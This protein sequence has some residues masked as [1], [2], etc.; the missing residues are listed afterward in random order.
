MTIRRQLTLEEYQYA[1]R[2]RAMAKNKRA[3]I[4]H[5]N[6]HVY[7]YLSREAAIYEAIKLLSMLEAERRVVI[8]LQKRRF[9][10][11]PREINLI[12]EMVYDY[13]HQGPLSETK[14]QL[15]VLQAKLA[16]W[17]EKGPI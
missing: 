17:Q 15:E 12:L 16:P 7:T 2:M 8:E 13:L 10:L 1:D 3:H 14:N 6:P 5:E 11:T 4:N 9:D